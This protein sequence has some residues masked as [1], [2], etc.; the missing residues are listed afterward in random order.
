MA[1]GFSVAPGHPQ[2]PQR[3]GAI[4]SPQAVQAHH[5]ESGRS[6]ETAP[7]GEMRF[8][9]HAFDCH[10]LLRCYSVDLAAAVTAAVRQAP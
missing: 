6:D 10:V 4:R 2:H 3:G 7:G 1:C 9:V 8:F 5:T